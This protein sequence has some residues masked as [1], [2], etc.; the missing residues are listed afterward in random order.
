MNF[1]T[2]KMSLD[3]SEICVKIEPKKI[4]CRTAHRNA[5]YF[6]S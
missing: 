4:K 6:D 1:L 3:I 5:A 2:N